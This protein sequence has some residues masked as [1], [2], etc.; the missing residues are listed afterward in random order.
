MSNYCD[1]QL[2]PGRTISNHTE[3]QAQA[4]AYHQ[5]LLVREGLKPDV[6]IVTIGTWTVNASRTDSN[7]RYGAGH[8]AE[9]RQNG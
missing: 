7:Y 9:R 8:E 3:E 1:E 4:S 6:P 5:E 2:Q